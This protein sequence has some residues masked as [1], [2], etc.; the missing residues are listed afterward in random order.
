VLSKKGMQFVYSQF[1]KV[2]LDFQ[3]EVQLTYNF[4]QGCENL[5]S[6]SDNVALMP[7]GLKIAVW[8][9]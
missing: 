2:S 1:I 7:L 3:G 5:T 6:W 9:L 4:S 8:G